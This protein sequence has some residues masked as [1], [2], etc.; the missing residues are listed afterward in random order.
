MESKS[1]IDQIIAK[2]LEEKINFGSWVGYMEFCFQPTYT[3]RWVEKTQ[4]DQIWVVIVGE[5]MKNCHANIK[6]NPYQF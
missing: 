2:S 6:E 5:I 3:A 1:V 4:I